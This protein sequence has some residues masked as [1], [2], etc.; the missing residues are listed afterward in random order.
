L[1][2]LP[3]DTKLRQATSSFCKISIEAVHSGEEALEKH[4]ERMETNH[5]SF[6]YDL[7]LMDEHL[8]NA[9]GKLKGSETTRL[10]RELGVRVVI[11]ACS[12][13]CLA[14]DRLLYIAAGASHVW[15]KPYPN[16]PDIAEDLQNWFGGLAARGSPHGG[17]G[18]DDGGSGRAQGT[19][20]GGHS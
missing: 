2:S 4:Q 11:V 5:P 7:V 13:N 20:R 14:D 18:P 8:E 10:L 9:G 19:L 12:G 17:Q 6:P 3:P 16:A 15:P 1:L